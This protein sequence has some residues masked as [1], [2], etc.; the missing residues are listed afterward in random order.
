MGRKRAVA[1]GALLDAAEAVVRRDG[2]ARLT[3]DAV[4]AEAGIS[5]SSVLYAVGSK[6]GL[7]R[8]I[9]ERRID[10]W[11]CGCAGRE[12]ELADR[13]NRTVEAVL[14]MIAEPIPQADRSVAVSLAA[15]VFA[16][17][18][19]REP[20]RKDIADRFARAERDAPAPT[21]ALC[22]LLA[23]EGL[24]SL[25]RLDLHQFEPARRDRL[26][27]AIAWIAQTEPGEGRVAPPAATDEDDGGAPSGGACA[28]PG[29]RGQG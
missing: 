13:P 25:E 12:A 7:I 15:A 20:I 23:I 18:A 6:R 29:C 19:L 4:A 11:R 2:A 21:G 8:A 9:I 5:K 26:L 24:L 14:E 3:L 17:E 10:D 1:D 16:D 27:S 22:A 28:L